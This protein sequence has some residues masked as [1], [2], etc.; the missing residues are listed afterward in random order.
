MEKMDEQAKGEVED[1][2]V[3]IHVRAGSQPVAIAQVIEH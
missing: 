1:V 2:H 3:H